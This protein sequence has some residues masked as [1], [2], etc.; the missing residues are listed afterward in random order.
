MSVLLAL[1]IAARN[2]NTNT[3]ARFTRHQTRLL[4]RVT[5]GVAVLGAIVAPSANAQTVA[6]PV[7]P[8]ASNPASATQTPVN[9][10]GAVPAKPAAAPALKPITF[11]S[12]KFPYTVSISNR[13]RIES[14]DFFQGELGAGA[15]PA[16]TTGDGKYAYLA[17]LLRV[18]ISRTTPKLDFT[19][20][21]AQ[22]SLLNL[23][24]DAIASGPGTTGQG[25]LG[26]GANY[27]RANNNHR[28]AYGFFPKQGFVRFKGLGDNF[29]S[30]RLGRFE[31]AEGA[32][33]APANASLAFLKRERIAQRLIGPFAFSHVGRAFDGAQF[34][35]N[36]PQKS[37]I[38]VMAARPTQGVF[39]V[40]GTGELRINFAYAAY[41]RPRPT[42]D[43]R[44]FGI[45]YRD[46]R[47]NGESVKVDN[48]A[49]G[50]RAA[51]G[52]G[53]TV[54]T[55]GAH[56]VQTFPTKSGSFDV[57]GWGALQSGKWG[58]L[59]HRA[60]AL[61]LEAGYQPRNFLP[62]LKPWL[63]V[64]YFRSSGDSSATDGK[65]ET[66]F[67]MLPTPRIYARFPFFNL[68]NNKDAFA[69]LI[70][71]PNPKLTLRA[72]AHALSLSNSSD[73]YYSGGG[74]FQDDGRDPGFNFG[75][76]GR[77]S[78][79]GRGLAKLFDLSAD[80]NLNAN[81]SFGAYIGYAPGKSVIDRIYRDKSNGT[82]GFLEVT[83][84]F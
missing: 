80:Y 83:N 49:A 3:N 82:F 69:Q 81:T 78:L 31:F 62:K 4:R 61:A 40:R 56:Y 18:G 39:D 79:G 76:A 52:Q 11:G 26:L 47:D 14:F 28:D 63:R 36:V 5:P 73:L 72:D 22:P 20:E 19:F 27:Y 30:L 42:S 77:P 8:P 6:P 38:T 74:A 75:F 64:G 15:T 70:L 57:L 25:L 67:Q 29:N 66:F 32:E 65:H 46:G 24:D 17:N 50:V 2:T 9:G 68:M 60:N 45:V 1:E 44:V 51:E 43:A 21:I 33:T 37:N 58:V 12:G 10:P 53:I 84:R 23:P 55:L 41:T 13:T 35:R 48:R 54:Q 59:D 71:R 34:V 16:S 7:A